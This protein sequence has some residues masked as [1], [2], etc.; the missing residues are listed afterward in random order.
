MANEFQNQLAKVVIQSLEKASA[1]HDGLGER[2]Q[3]MV[4]KNQF[5]ETALRADIECERAILDYLREMQIPIRVISEEHGQ[6]DITD[7]PHYLGILDGL[8]GSN[9]YQSTH[10]AGRYGTMFG[11]FANLNPLYSDYTASG[12]MEHSS[13]KMFTAVKG[14][15]AF[16]RE[17]GMQTPMHASGRTE[18]GADTN[19]YID[20]A[21]DLNRET[22]S[23][24]LQAWK[25]AT[26]EFSSGSSAI[27]YADV[28]AGTADLA[29]ECTR[30]N[31]LEIAIAYGL[32]SEAGGAMIDIEGQPLGDK[33][34]LE[35]GQTE[36]IPIITAATSELAQVLLA[37][38]KK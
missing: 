15:G 11:I 25:P 27:H 29:L 38:I 9:V 2:G 13:K 22:F 4:Q 10:G 32:I 34:Y 33:K 3:E 14:D 8:D 30:K 31:N 24:K 5:G 20:E 1:V 17:G 28:A 16:V 37:H 21:F 6:V 26:R 36:K 7:D 35:F 18:L 19:I 12:I 23:K